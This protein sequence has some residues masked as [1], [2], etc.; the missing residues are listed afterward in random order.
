MFQGGA[1]V[2][3]TDRLVEEP[4]QIPAVPLITA[5]GKALTVTTALP[6]YEVPEQL[7]SLTAV[8]E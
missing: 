3:A 6:V 8:K 5:V 7:A 1:P 2:K 4:E